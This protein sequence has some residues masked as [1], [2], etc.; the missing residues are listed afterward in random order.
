MTGEI[1]QLGMVYASALFD[2]AGQAKL[3]DAVKNDLDAIAEIAVREPEFAAFAA[4]PYFT[5]EIKAQIV[6]KMFAGQVADLTL[7]FLMI[8]IRRNRLMNIGEIAAAFGKMWDDLNGYKDVSV[9]LAKPASDEEISKIT[10]EI[11]EAIA[12]RVKL[13][14]S[15]DDSL[16]GGIV[17]RFGDKIID[18]SARAQLSRAVKTIMTRQVKGQINEV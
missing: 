18:N 4:S 2:L 16:I 13:K 14:V 17:I 15:I 11:S 6:R 7:D 8:V 1:S 5:K 3:V 12:A 10:R 9:T